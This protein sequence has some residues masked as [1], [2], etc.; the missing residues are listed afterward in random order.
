MRRIVLC[1][2]SALVLATG[3]QAL[4]MQGPPDPAKEMARKA[5]KEIAEKKYRELKDAASELAALSREISDAVEQ[6]GQHVI[7][8]KIFDKLDKIEKLARR[9]RDKAKA[10]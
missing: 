5:E 2:L 9:I 4:G 6:G 8:A 7:S 10:P 3:F 1:A